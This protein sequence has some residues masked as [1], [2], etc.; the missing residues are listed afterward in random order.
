MATPHV[1]AAAALARAK[2]GAL[3]PAEMKT[4]LMGA[5]DKVAGMNG[6][7]FTSRYGAGRL[8]LT[9]L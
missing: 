8:N 5:A 1:T 7:E 6:Q 2:H 9:K 4:T 3:S